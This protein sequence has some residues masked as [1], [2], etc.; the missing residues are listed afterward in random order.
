MAA[1]LGPSPACPVLP[2]SWWGSLLR[3]REVPGSQLVRVGELS[4]GCALGEE[5]SSGRVWGFVLG[6]SCPGASRT[7]QAY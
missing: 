1:G 3:P 4:G 6:G 5:G 2:I 7:A